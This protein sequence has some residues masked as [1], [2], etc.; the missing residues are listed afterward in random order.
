MDAYYQAHAR[1]L[2]LSAEP[3]LPGSADTARRERP[4]SSNRRDWRRI[5][6]SWHA[7]RLPLAIIPAPAP[8]TTYLR[9]SRSVTSIVDCVELYQLRGVFQVLRVRTR[10]STFPAQSQN[11]P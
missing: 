4:Y 10:P 2:R 6:R 5:G 3:P 8:R 7:A 1:T 11:S 9:P